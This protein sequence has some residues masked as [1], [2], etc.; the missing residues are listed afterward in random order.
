MASTF[1]EVLDFFVEIGIYDVVL[2]FLLIFTIVF[3][4]LE[5]TKVL[6]TETWEG[7][8]IPKKNLNAMVSFVMAFMVILSARL[9]AIITQISSQMVVLLL[10]SIFFL[11]LVGSFYKE[12]EGIFLEEGWKRT[13]M[14]IMFIGIIL[15]FLNAIRTSSGESWLSAFWGFIVSNW[16][17]EWVA[18][19][20]FIVII[21]LFM[22][23]IVKD[24]KPTSD[25]KEPKKEG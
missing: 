11:I 12:G 3:A 4:I 15:V 18:S 25:K 20:I 17:T 7:K 21:V 10:L 24:K 13:F 19:I 8:A 9:V 1:R 14:W 23:Y 2:P 22:W 5:K 16:R 6:G